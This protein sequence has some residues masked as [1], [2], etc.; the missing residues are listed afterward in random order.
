MTGLVWEEGRW[1][2]AWAPHGTAV[3]A[4]VPL[5][6]MGRG[7]VEGVVTEA[8]CVKLVGPALTSL[9]P[10]VPWPSVEGLLYPYLIEKEINTQR[11]NNLS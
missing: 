8:A 4:P 11:V 10:S 2:E 6:S 9:E 3:P 7:E 1:M 5:V